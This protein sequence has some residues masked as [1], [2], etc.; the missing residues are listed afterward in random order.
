MTRQVS[1]KKVLLP[2]FLRDLSC[3]FA[4]IL[5]IPRFSENHRKRSV[6]EGI[7]P[8]D[9]MHEAFRMTSGAQ[10]RRHGRYTHVLG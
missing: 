4:T 8:R 1:A 7:V 5:P 10:K 3:F 9:D 6:F 2:S